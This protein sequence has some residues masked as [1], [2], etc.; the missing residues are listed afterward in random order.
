MLKA[1]VMFILEVPAGYRVMFI[2]EVPAG[3]RGAE[4]LCNVY[5]RGARWISCNVYFRGARW[6]SWC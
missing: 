1:C 4:G 5:F 6:I 3:Y 2:L